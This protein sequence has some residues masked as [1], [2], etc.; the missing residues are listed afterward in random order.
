[1]QY[2]AHRS[3]VNILTA[4]K[5]I[6]TMVNDPRRVVGNKVQAKAFHVTSESESRRLYG[7]NWKTK[8]LDGIVTAVRDKNGGNTS[9]RKRSNW[10]ITAE[11]DVGDN[12]KVKELNIRSVLKVVTLP[13]TRDVVNEPVDIVEN[14][15][16]AE[17][18]DKNTTGEKNTLSK[19]RHH[20]SCTCTN[21]VFIIIGAILDS[22]VNNVNNKEAV[23]S[24]ENT[25]LADN[26]MS[27]ENTTGEKKN[28]FQ[29]FTDQMSCTCTNS[30]F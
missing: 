26:R 3:S 13:T 19:N 4:N 8:L 28:E 24:V 29:I 1:M 22:N 9:A 23:D 27:V 14:T 11:Y 21:S 2:I 12:K 18:N 10:M 15:N 16:L 6:A 25:N 7:S 17:N 30:V 20:S 5:K